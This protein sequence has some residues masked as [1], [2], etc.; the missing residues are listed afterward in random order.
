M[1]GGTHIV[2]IRHPGDEP[3]K[4]RIPVSQASAQ[5][6]PGGF[7]IVAHP[8]QSFHGVPQDGRRDRTRSPALECGTPEQRAHADR[9]RRVHLSDLGL[10]L[11]PQTL[12]V[13]ALLFAMRVIW[14]R[15]FPWHSRASLLTTCAHYVKMKAG[16]AWDNAGLR[17]GPGDVVLPSA[18][19]PTM[20]HRS[21]QALRDR[22][23]LLFAPSCFAMIQEQGDLRPDRRRLPSGFPCLWRDGFSLSAP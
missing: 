3:L 11:G 21:G 15:R 20:R 23:A 22:S 16:L 1:S 2:S 9:D 18:R 14:D 8:D 13:A 6:L 10:P 17:R 5:Q 19:S 12:T 7:L 4:T